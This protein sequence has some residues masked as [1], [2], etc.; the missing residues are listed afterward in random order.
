MTRSLFG[1][2][3]ETALSIMIQRALKKEK[4]CWGVYDNVLQKPTACRWARLWWC[5]VVWQLDAIEWATVKGFGL[6]AKIRKNLTTKIKPK[7]P[8]P[9]LVLR[10][11]VKHVA[12]WLRVVWFE[13]CDRM[14]GLPWPRFPPRT[15]VRMRVLGDFK[16]SSPLMKK[17]GDGLVAGHTAKQISISRCP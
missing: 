4:L 7:F 17:R 15:S 2:R 1:R 6:F 9:Y 3:D 10:G 11:K 16:R 13:K 5:V 12:L 8:F 14:R